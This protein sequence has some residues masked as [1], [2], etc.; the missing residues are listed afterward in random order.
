MA[1]PQDD[2][3]GLYERIYA[4]VRAVP[5]GRV[6]TYGQVAAIAGRCTPRVVGYAMAAV[7]AGSGVPWHRVINSRGEISLRRDGEG[8]RVQRGLLES[9]GIAFDDRG[10][11]DLARFG[12]T[13]PRTRS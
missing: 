7:P 13:G 9:E 1:T 12:W 11:V 6:A 3:P 8:H 10:R 4:I 2:G 5:E